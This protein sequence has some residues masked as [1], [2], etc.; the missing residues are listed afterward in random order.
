MN[1][2]D[3][4]NQEICDKLVSMDFTNYNH[5]CKTLGYE[6]GDVYNY[7]M[8]KNYCKIM[9]NNNYQADKDYTYRDTN[10]ELRL[11]VEGYGLQKMTA[12]FRNALVAGLYTDYDIVN[13]QPSII[14][15]ILKQN[16]CDTSMMYDYIIDRD[17]ILNE[18]MELYDIPRWESKKLILKSIN[19]PYIINKVNKKLVKKNSWFGKFNEYCMAIQK[20]LENR[21]DN[22]V[23]ILKNKK[24]YHGGKLMNYLYTKIESKILNICKEKYEVKVPIFDGFLSNQDIPIDELIALTNQYGITWKKNEVKNEIMDLLESDGKETLFGLS[25]IDIR[26]K[27]LNGYLLNKYFMEGG[28][29]YMKVNGEWT[30]NKNRIKH[31]ISNILKGYDIYVGEEKKYKPVNTNSG[32]TGIENEIYK[33]PVINDNFTRDIYEN[34][35]YKLVFG[36]GYYD[37]KLGKYINQEIDSFVAI[38]KEL[39][40][41]SNELVRQEIYDLVLN[42]IFSVATHRKDYEERLVLRDYFLYKMSR[43]MAGHIEDKNWVLMLGLRDSGKGVLMDFFSNCFEKYIS[44]T[45]AGSFRFRSNSGA[46]N[47]SWI[48]D[49][50][51][52]RLCLVSEIPMENM[53]DSID[54]NMIKKFCSGGDEIEGRQNYMDERKFKIQSSLVICCNDLP[55]INPADA[56]EKA[57]P[58]DMKT[59]FV[60]KD[61]ESNDEVLYWKKNDWVKTDFIRNPEVMNEFILMIIDS[62]SKPITYPQNLLDKFFEEGDD[63]DDS[64]LYKLFRKNPDAE[65]EY[66]DIKYLV[67]ASNIHMTQRMVIKKLKIKYSCISRKSN[68]KSI[69]VGIEKY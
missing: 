53:T 13:S 16:H 62:Y 37:F 33:N 11:Y 64:K 55:K 34:T 6:C 59:K 61:M 48:I 5:I 38:N 43:I 26:D 20:Q 49:F 41:E 54:G 68:G 69:L 29:R 27:I 32:I 2:T 36:N 40:F 25:P 15:Y 24:D 57:I 23:S 52:R 60:D 19:S 39:N 30:D 22:L 46:K 51:H 17:R 63:D 3:I 1:G 66:D 12:I 14:L 18:L 31:N 47:N 45:D 67:K 56:L 44:T 42:P 58:I 10:R 9:K 4:V 21:Y 8:I 35:K 65:V 7:T 50:I 28:N